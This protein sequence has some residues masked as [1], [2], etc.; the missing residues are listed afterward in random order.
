MRANLV[1]REFATNVMLQM[2]AWR[3]KATGH[4][5]IQTYD[6]LM[7]SLVRDTKTKVLEP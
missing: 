7:L 1:R 2:P 4:I 6:S 3:F 5:L